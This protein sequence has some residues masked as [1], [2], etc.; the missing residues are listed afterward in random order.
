MYDVL[1]TGGWPSRLARPLGL[2]GRLQVSAHD[3]P[4]VVPGPPPPPLRIGFVSDLHAGPATHPSLDVAACRALADWKPDLLFLGG[5]YVSFHA[6]H[7]DPLIPLIA[8]IPAPLGKLAVFGNHDLI[9]DER[10]IADRLRDAGARMLCNESVQLPAPYDRV[11]VCGLDDFD[12]GFPDTAAAFANTGDIRIVLMHSPDCVGVIGTCP[13]AMAFCGHVHGGQFRL[14]DGRTLI[15]FKGEY[16]RRYMS[17]GL[18]R[19]VEP[20]GD[21]VLLVSRGIG[22]GSLPMRRRAD[23]EVHLVTLRFHIADRADRADSRE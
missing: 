9:G 17:G 20:Q 2:T 16:S 10:Y 12:E 18:F 11:S 15:H 1:Y 22:C 4:L 19:L 23:P 3:V 7:L 5:D 8:A 13:F 21:R 6:R 14:D